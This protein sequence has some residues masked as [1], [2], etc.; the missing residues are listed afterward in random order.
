M[1]RPLQ[2]MR[3]RVTLA[4]HLRALTREKSVAYRRHPWQQVGIT[5]PVFTNTAVA[6][7]HD[8]SQGTPRRHN[9][10]AQACLLAAYSTQQPCGHGH[11]GTP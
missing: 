7:G 6:A 1:L 11:G 4:S 9:R 8:W 10:W 5:R 2:T 3:Q